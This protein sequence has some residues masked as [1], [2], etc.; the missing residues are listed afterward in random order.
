MKSVVV[1]GVST[2]IGRGILKVLTQQGIHVFGSV[3]QRQDA[4]RLTAEFGNLFTPLVFDVTDE[5]AVQTAAQLVR[6]RMGGTT[7]FGLVNNAG[8][9]IGGPLMHQPIKDFRQLLEVNLVGALIVSQAFI[10]LLGADKSLKGEPGRIVNISSTGGK[11]GG[12]FL[13][14]YAAS[15][16]GLEGMSESLRR[17]L[18]LYG[19]D[20]IIVG[21][22]AVATPIWDKAESQVVSVFANT[23][24]APIA[25][26]FTRYF[27]NQGRKGFPPEKIGEVVYTALTVSH[28]RVRYPVVPGFVMNW[29]MPTLLP[30][31]MIDRLIANRLG[32]KRK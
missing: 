28:P 22:G 11:I 32:L 4:E 25:A 1:T 8:I 3:R 14:G 19:I 20:V 21:P 23:D 2:G 26:Q 16:H 9:G 6:E 27:I 12:P 13:G 17:E 24:Y 5:K 30:K 15:K 18:M 10:P 29:L 31:R 7:L